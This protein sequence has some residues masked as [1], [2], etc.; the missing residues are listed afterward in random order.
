MWLFL[1]IAEKY[2]LHDYASLSIRVSLL[3]VHI[4]V[5]WRLPGASITF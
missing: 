2:K 4:P 1:F 3:G 5:S